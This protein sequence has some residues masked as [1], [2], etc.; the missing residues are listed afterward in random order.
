MVI[1]REVFFPELGELRMVEQSEAQLLFLERLHRR[2]QHQRPGFDRVEDAVGALHVGEVEELEE[3]VEDIDAAGGA[4]DGD[5]GTVAHLHDLGGGDDVH[6]MA[7][8][9]ELFAEPLEFRAIGRGFVA[10]DDGDQGKFLLRCQAGERGH[11]PVRHAVGAD[12]A[13]EVL[14][15]D[16]VQVGREADAAGDAVQLRHR[17]ALLGDEQVRTKDDGAL[18]FDG[19]MAAMFD[20]AGGLIAVEVFGDPGGVDLT[21]A[22]DLLVREG[23][24]VEAFECAVITEAG[25]ADALQ[26]AQLRLGDGPRLRRQLPDLLREE[27]SIEELLAEDV[28]AGHG[29]GGLSPRS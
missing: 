13:G 9:A 10:D 12:D 4:I 20:E 17:E 7:K 18:A 8:G 29:G 27:R 3:A 21:V 16:L 15:V 14:G 25:R 19:A 23:A 5:V 24:D 2:R 11:E 22:E 1:L 28:P 26:V 6:V